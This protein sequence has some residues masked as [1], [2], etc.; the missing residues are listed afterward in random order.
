MSSPAVTGWHDGIFPVQA[1][2]V[3]FLSDLNIHN[4]LFTSDAVW[5]RGKYPGESP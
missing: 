1:G 2:G 3:T 4:V 5:H